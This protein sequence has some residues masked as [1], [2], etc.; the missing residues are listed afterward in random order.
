MCTWCF[1][2]TVYSERH[3]PIYRI[4]EIDQ[5][6]HL[7]AN[8]HQ[9]VTY[10]QYILQLKLYQFSIPV[11]ATGN[12][13]ILNKR[14]LIGG[15]WEMERRLTKTRSPPIGWDTQN[16]TEPLKVDPEQSINADLKVDVDVLG[17]YGD[18]KLNSGRIIQLFGRPGPFYGFLCSILNC[19]LPPTSSKWHYIR[20]VCEVSPIR[21]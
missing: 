19:I 14:P 5:W 2:L 10:F 9:I 16:A 13:V 3:A 12:F 4:D 15:L 20:Q 8:C 18:S 1:S 21:V 17:K 6:N 11:S 7:K